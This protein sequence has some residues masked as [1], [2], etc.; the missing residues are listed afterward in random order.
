M[1]NCFADE[2]PLCGWATALRV[3]KPA[4]RVKDSSQNKPSPALWVNKACRMIKLC[5]YYLFCGWRLAFARTS[6]FADNVHYKYED[7]PLRRL[8]ALRILFT[9][10]WRLAFAKTSCFADTV[11]YADED[12]PLRRPH[13]LR[14]L[15]TMRMKSSCAHVICFAKTVCFADQLELF[16][17]AHT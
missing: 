14:T 5:E 9:C 1:N 7:L 15:F 3:N 17:W 2:E 11:H 4:L 8:H 12:L 16:G 13:A 10:G 6:C